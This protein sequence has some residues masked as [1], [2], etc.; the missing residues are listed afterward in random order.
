MKR[1]FATLIILGLAISPCFADTR[2]NPTT[3]VKTSS[4]LI[5]TGDAKIYRVDFVATSNNGAFSIH[6]ATT[7]NVLTDIKAE[8]SEATS[9]NSKSYDFTNL[10]NGGLELSTGLY[11]TITTGTATITYD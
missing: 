8:G 1:I 10:P 7:Q 9:G 3:T 5:K 2:G 4:V 11:L 6:D